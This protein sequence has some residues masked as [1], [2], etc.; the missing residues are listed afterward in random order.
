LKT[1]LGL[2]HPLHDGGLNA[3]DLVGD[4]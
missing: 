3:L 4:I 1:I 2:N